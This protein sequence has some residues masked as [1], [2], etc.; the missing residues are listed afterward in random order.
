[1]QDAV[2]E[3]SIHSIS[4][5]KSFVFVLPSC[6][7]SMMQIIIKKMCSS[8]TST[9]TIAKTNKDLPS[10]P[11]T[12]PS[13]Q[14]LSSIFGEIMDK[15]CVD[16]RTLFLVDQLISCGGVV[17]FCRGVVLEICSLHCKNELT[18]AGRLLKEYLTL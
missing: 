3:A 16:R 10:L 11:L 14:V 4:S 17:W 6:R 13:S 7:N 2:N 15:G 8:S 5:I 12:T 9:N 18:M 1:M